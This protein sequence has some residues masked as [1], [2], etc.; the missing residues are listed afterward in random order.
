MIRTFCLICTV[1]ALS[2]GCDSNSSGPTYEA[3]DQ[4]IL[5]S[6]D[7]DA[8]LEYGPSADANA[9]RSI[10]PVLGQTTI[11]DPKKRAELMN[12]L[13]AGLDADGNS[14]D[15][16]IPRHAI[17]VVEGEQITDYVICFECLQVA[18]YRGDEQTSEFTTDSP[19]GVFNQYL[20]DAGLPLAP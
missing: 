18:I 14:A 17:R 7:G 11:E 16:F 20:R 6:I 8:V 15:C 3:A 12:A 4:F 9:F 19:R 10:W 5:Y 13:H 2:S 1:I